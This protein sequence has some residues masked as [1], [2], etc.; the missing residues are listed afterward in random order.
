MAENRYL[1]LLETTG[2]HEVRIAEAKAIPLSDDALSGYMDAAGIAA[3]RA[4]GIVLKSV[5]VLGTRP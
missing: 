3:F 2:F 5:T 4:S 1:G